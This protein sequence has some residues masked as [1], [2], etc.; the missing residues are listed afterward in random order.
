MR[1]IFIFLI[2]LMPL[3]L[4]AAQWG[5]LAD[6]DQGDSAVRGS[7]AGQNY[8]MPQILRGEPVRIF[9]SVD[10]DHK[11]ASYE[12]II[13][14]S[15]AR[16]FA[17]PAQLIRKAKR[18]D[19]FADILPLL[20]RGIKV[21]FVSS[22]EQRDID[23][24]VLPLGQVQAVCGR[25]SGGCYS[26]KEGKIPQILIPKDNFLRQVLTRGQLSA[27]RIGLHEI[28]HSLGLSDQYKRARSLN[29]HPVY[30]TDESSKSIMNQAGDLTCDDADGIINLIDVT[31]GVS[32]GGTDGWH[33]LCKNDIY[34]ING[35][36]ADKLPYVV[37][38]QEKGTVWML[39]EYK[40]GRKTA[41]REF[42]LDMQGE[43]SVFDDISERVLLRDK[44]G[45]PLRSVGSGGEE[46]Y[47][48][49]TYDKHTRLLVK[50]GKVLRV[51]IKVPAYYGKRM[52]KTAMG[53]VRYFGEG[54]KLATLEYLRSG[55]GKSKAG[56]ISYKVGV[57]DE[58]LSVDIELSFDAEGRETV[59]AA[60]VG[61]ATDASDT[62]PAHHSFYSSHKMAG[63]ADK[64]EKI[65]ARQLQEK[66]RRQMLDAKIQEMTR[67]YLS[68]P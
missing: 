41:V 68:R 40:N 54:G 4:A 60:Y 24:A 35:A 29:S 32:R 65:L 49:Y 55:K 3:C 36:P 39:T 19:E 57:L 52:N 6:Y 12:K 53:N 11:T 44:S 15:Y 16:W 61:Q 22:S 48:S 13:T 18:E 59:H 7:I 50:D 62:V 17:R 34:Y 58:R 45:R 14:D 31:Q 38:G 9:L 33:S 26:R 30:S 28:G 66:A 42:P 37:V 27:K 21:N 25:A 8:L 67:W 56:Y 43:I 20:D 46:I 5:I 23:I 1:K 64:H 10:G 63:K 2:C 47:Y 51:D